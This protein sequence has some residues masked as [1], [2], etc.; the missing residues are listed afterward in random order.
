MHVLAAPDKLRGSLTGPEVAAAIAKGVANVG[1]TCRQLPLADGGEG[2]LEAFGGP[3]QHTLVTGP[4]GYPVH[5]AWRLDP[6]GRAIIEMARASGLELAGGPEANDPVAAT[7]RGV[8]ELIATALRAGAQKIIVGMGGSATTDGGRG[9]LQALEESG[10][11]HQE[12]RDAEILVCCDVL[13]PF[14]MAAEVFSPQKGASPEE[15]AQLTDRLRRLQAEYQDSYGVDLTHLPGAGAAGGLAGGLATMGADLVPGF[16]LI[17]NEAVLQSALSDA[18]IV[19]TG[20][21]QLDAGSFNGKV[22][23]GI[24][25]ATRQRAKPVLAIVGHRADGAVEDIAYVSLLATYGHDKAWF[26]TAAC[27]E[28]AVTDHLNR[29]QPVSAA[30]Q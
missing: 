23:G 27:I 9:A 5:A 15:T 19:I 8:G 26:N 14:T 10:L 30:R 13:T 3:N 18:D 28:Q 21:G 2:T 7:T 25:R 12:I 17:A 22:V 24:F 4:S 16:D 20:E 11:S 6:D 1:G 29:A